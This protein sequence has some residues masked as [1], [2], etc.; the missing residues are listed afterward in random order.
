MMTMNNDWSGRL[1]ERPSLPGTKCEHLASF[2]ELN[3]ALL[4]D[5][6]RFSQMG[7]DCP[8]N[9]MRI[10][11]TCGMKLCE[12]HTLQLHVTDF[13][14]FLMLDIVPLTCQC[15]SCGRHGMMLE[16]IDE[17][18]SVP[19]Q[20]LGLRGLHNTGNTCFMNSVWQALSN[21][22][23]FR[24]KILQRAQENDQQ[25]MKQ[26]SLFQA[27]VRLLS[28]LWSVDAADSQ[29]MGNGP[30]DPQD[31]F[32][33]IKTC[34]PLFGDAAQHDAH[35][36]LRFF[37]DNLHAEESW[38]TDVF[39]GSLLSEVSCLRC[40]IV[41]RKVDPCLDISL[42]FPADLVIPLIVNKNGS[43]EAARPLRLHDC[44]RH[45]SRVEH[46]DWGNDDACKA[47]AS[48]ALTAIPQT[49]NSTSTTPEVVATKR[50]RMLDMPQVLV[51]HFKRFRWSFYATSTKIARY[52]QFPLKGLKLQDFRAKDSFGNSFGLGEDD[53][54]AYDLVS[55]VVH[56]GR[57]MGVSWMVSLTSNVCLAGY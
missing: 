11:L 42:D 54:V 36:F 21:T 18:L 47:C 29:K 20:S 34:I 17:A 10:C 55:V 41:T 53:G 57:A 12:D 6:I 9:K 26:A 1:R 35:E 50:L 44:L 22:K 24:E 15:L 30:L 40:Q 5:R 31:L 39:G 4:S 28:K 23:D 56:H 19:L 51:I 2:G 52:V 37:S 38:T 32:N 16:G 8:A 3:T 27:W 14:H 48:A 49:I 13:G 25:N 7:C 46:I 45:F 43:A 33:L